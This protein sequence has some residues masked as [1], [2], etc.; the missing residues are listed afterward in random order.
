MTYGEVLTFVGCVAAL[1]SLQA[2][3]FKSYADAKFDPLSKSVEAGLT[4]LGN[5]RE[6]L[7]RIET[8]LHIP[9]DVPPESSRGPRRMP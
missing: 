4:S 2:L 5:V 6:R 1:M 3:W 9:Q 8:H 7:V